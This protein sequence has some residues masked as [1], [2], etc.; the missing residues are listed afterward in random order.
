MASQNDDFQKKA[1]RI[2]SGALPDS[3]QKV[4]VYSEFQTDYLNSLF[5]AQEEDG[6]YT[7]CYDLAPAHNLD[8]NTILDEI[9]DLLDE[10]RLALPEEERWT[11]MTI[12]FTPDGQST[13]EL[14][15]PDIK[16]GSRE[17]RRGWRERYLV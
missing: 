15:Y 14:D 16:E 11:V 8:L 3:W 4:I 17:Y 5:Y 6:S 7:D 12:T 2:V 13:V 10:R 9:C 1:L